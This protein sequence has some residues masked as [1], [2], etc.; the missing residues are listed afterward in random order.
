MGMNR[1]GGLANLEL[2]DMG[3]PYKFPVLPE[4]SN[5]KQ[6]QQNQVIGGVGYMVLK[7]EQ[8]SDRNNFNSDN[9]LGMFLYV[10]N[11]ITCIISHFLFCDAYNPNYFR[12]P[13][14][15][16][17]FE[18]RSSTFRWLMLEIHSWHIA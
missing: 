5:F 13:H 2:G 18:K 9:D 15:W 16:D 3:N 14:N 4:Y 10:K 6:Q 12:Y 17:L 11:E 1:P 8:N 7:E